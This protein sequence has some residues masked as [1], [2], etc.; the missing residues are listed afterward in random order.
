MIEYA[1]RALPWTLLL[2]CVGLVIVAMAL[3]GRW[4]YVMWPLQGIAVGV[5][6]AAGAWCVDEPAAAVVDSVPRD[7]WW[8]TTARTLGLL[9]VLAVWITTV[10]ATRGV[11]FGH[12]LDVAVQGCVALVAGC[13]IGTWARTRGVA[14][15][16]RRIAAATV[17]AVAFW[18]LVRPVDERLPIFPFLEA[19]PW[20][21]SRGLWALVGGLAVILL[22]ISLM[23][24]GTSHRR[25]RAHA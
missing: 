16:G 1:R 24:R 10:V 17:P 23:G 4:P 7:L 14:T 25:V 19:G 13:A 3:V 6:A 11:L 15:P 9:P 12:A 8:R 20:G 21:S 5:L 22:I 2:W 18:A